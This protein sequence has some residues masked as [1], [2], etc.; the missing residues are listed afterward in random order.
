V[1][2]LAASWTRS[3]FNTSQCET[4]ICSAALASVVA[5]ICEAN[6]ANL[7]VPRQKTAHVVQK[8]RE[9]HAN[10][11]ALQPARTC[12]CHRP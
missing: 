6:C 8:G 4:W 2:L 9:L 12:D 5:Q 10:R 1:L 7:L 11:K 3:G